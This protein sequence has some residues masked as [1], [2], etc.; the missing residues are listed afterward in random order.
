MSGF[1]D[2]F[3]ETKDKKTKEIIEAKKYSN[4]QSIKDR[5]QEKYDELDKK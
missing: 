4:Y 5:E 1:W 2:S 3:R